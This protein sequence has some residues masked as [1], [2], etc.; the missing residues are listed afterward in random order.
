MSHARAG[1]VVVAAHALLLLVA[2][3]AGLRVGAAPRPE[4]TPLQ[5]SLLAPQRVAPRRQPVMPVPPAP[6]PTLPAAPVMTAPTIAVMAPAAPAAAPQ[7]LPRAAEPVSPP[8]PA[9]TAPPARVAVASTPPAPTEPALT[10]ARAD[11]RRCPPAPHPVALRERGIEGVV[12]LRVRVGSDGLPAEVNVS[13]GSGWLLMDQAA[14][15]QVRGCRFLPAR[16]GSE[17][18][19]SWVEF[20]VRFVLNG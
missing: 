20:P 7:P 18:V 14:L 12:H 16:R 19:E 9:P 8:A 2:W 13:A 6:T 11:H 17:P 1:F 5:V 10:Q 4:A 15:N 3:Q